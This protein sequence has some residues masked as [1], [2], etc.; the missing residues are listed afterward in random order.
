M[1][2]KR[3]LAALTLL[4]FL[5]VLAVRP[6]RAA[7]E[8]PVERRYT[9]RTPD[10]MVALARA[11]ATADGATPLDG[12]SAIATIGRL[13]D[14]ANAKLVGGA[15]GAI[16]ESPKMS[17]DVRDEAYLMRR[18]FEVDAA[19]SLAQDRARGLLTQVSVLGPFRDTGGGLDRREGPEAPGAAFG[20]ARA[21]Y[22]W[23]AVRVEWRQ[24][25]AA[26]GG[27]RGLP[28]DVFVAP[29]KES[30]T[31]V[32]SRVTLATGG[33]L[34]V[35]VAASGQVRL[36]WDGVDVAKSDEVHRA[37][38]FDRLAASVTAEAGSHIVGVKVCSGAL[39]D[40]GRVRLRIVGPGGARVELEQ[41]AD[42]AIQGDRKRAKVE[43]VTTPL[44]AAL[45]TKEPGIDARLASAV[46]RSL[47]GADDLRSPRIGGALDQLARMPGI[48][49]DR[50]ATVAWIS[51][52]GPN[53]TGW[54][55]R[56]LEGARKVD[57][58][59]ASVAERRLV[60]E[61]VQAQLADWGMATY[62]G[63]SQDRSDAEGELF[64]AQI[65]HA[66][67]V[68]ALRADAYRILARRFER[69]PGEVPLA[70][71][72]ELARVASAYDRPTSRRVE[73]ELAR[74][75]FPSV[76]LVVDAES[77]AVAERAAEHLLDGRVDDAS[78]AL[79]VVRALAGQGAH[80]KAAE[81]GERVASWSPN[82]ADVF[83]QVAHDRAVTGA[84]PAVVLKVLQRARDLA[85]TEAQLRIEMELRDK[86]RRGVAAPAG[87]ERHLAAPE[88]IL[89]RRR[90]VP[91]KGPPDVADREL[92]WLRAVIM[93]PDNRVSQLIHYARE[94]VIPPRTQ[95]ELF[96]DIPAE[97]ELTE[98]LRARVHRKAGGVA[99]PTEEHNDGRRPRIRWPEL[100]PGD[101]VEVALRTWTSTAVGGRGDAPF[102]FL[103]YAGAPSTHPLLYNEVVVE[104]S[105]GHPLHVDVLRGTGHN[106]TESSEAGRQVVRYVW[107]K[108]DVVPEEPL[109]PPLSETVPVIVGSTF[110]T[111]ADFKKWYLE[112]VRGFTEP[113][114]EV[115]RLAAE[116]TRG[117]TSQDARV[118]ALFDFVA[119]DIRYVNYVSGEWWLPN[120]P[121][122]LLARREGDCDDK[123]LLLITLLKAIGVEAEEVMV[124][125]RLTGQP[126]VVLAKNVAVPMFDH[127]IAFL[128]GP[129][130]GTYLDATS[131]QS[132]MG[133]LP[134]MDAH[135]VALRL[136]GGSEIVQLPAS[137]PED[138]GSDVTWNI[139]LGADG[140]G[141]LAGEE[142]HSGDGAFVLR[143][144][145]A[146]PDAR[147]QYVEDNL[148]GPWFP[149]VE[150]DK[151][152]DFKGDLAGGRAWV[153]YKARS[154]GYARGD[155][156]DLVVSLS[157][158]ATLAS[159]LAPLPTRTLPVA[160]PPHTAPSHQ[161]RTVRIL[162]PPG[163]D[164]ADLPPGGEVVGGDFGRASLEVARDP[165]RA[166]G[167][168]VR[169]NVTLKEHLVGVDKYPA[170]RRFITSIDAL[171]HRSVRLVRDGKRGGR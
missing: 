4:A 107:E 55:H 151:A 42:L 161:A 84:D 165:A 86:V 68:E 127:G 60:A 149:T 12:L 95:N 29:R 120:R 159:A 137:R 28:L 90:G 21:S 148:V 157:P 125:T 8:G 11:R 18:R 46:V 32:A 89:A 73:A 40:D 7:A 111:W 143:T 105:Q 56:A 133:P 6:P 23:G 14:R 75:G 112:A 39:A 88:T 76:G 22:S 140:A 168:V 50:L 118:R 61:Q 136:S 150:V 33:P 13:F 171:M 131:P 160:L 144:Y 152:I 2:D 62:R 163:F 162:A 122:Q 78:E 20:D 116:L 65:L 99:F 51:P 71:L 106:R 1:I 53:R 3:S 35:R 57:P 169:R 31:I 81:L 70:W 145:V 80:A 121:Q 45:S 101:T 16:A 83:T 114:D 10:E 74:R 93:H 34:Q 126:S 135:G 170:W 146:Q 38:W 54:F 19:E 141:E 115:R 100:F 119:D 139:T 24:V 27:P 91:D 30:C 66:L 142:V 9:S 44:E 123:A 52:S 155:H 43:R 37:A 134:S 63:L 25:P 109:A 166:R 167:I 59:T 94:I 72:Y 41:S 158:S 15:L 156:G 124:Q 113:D 108:P 130:G 85:P 17:W 77:V 110:K 87:D 47:A 138:H 104:T 98:L 102:Y 147:L 58:R 67:G 36:F 154:L 153:R 103:D 5:P 82:R 49:D 129:N 92:H 96:E 79:S 117:K 26:F 69:E 48:L 64:S 128:P 97:G 132:R 164:W